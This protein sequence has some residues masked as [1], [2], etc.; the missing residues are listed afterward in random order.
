MEV[1]QYWVLGF[2]LWN[3]PYSE[4]LTL[5]CQLLS[6][7]LASREQLDNGANYHQ[8]YL[9]VSLLRLKLINDKVPK[10]MTNPFITCAVCNSLNTGVQ[11]IMIIDIGGFKNIN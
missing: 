3:I 10:T 7:T 4:D 8:N 6:N 1:S 2:T 5:N 9:N 11:I